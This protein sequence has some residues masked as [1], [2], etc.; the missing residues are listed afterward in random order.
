MADDAKED[1]ERDRAEREA[2]ALYLTDADNRPQVPFRKQDKS[3]RDFYFQYAREHPGL[4]R[5][6]VE[7]R[8]QLKNVLDRI[9]A[10]TVGAGCSYSYDCEIRDCHQKSMAEV[11]SIPVI[12]GGGGVCDCGITFKGDS[13]L[14]F[15]ADCPICNGTGQIPDVTEVLGKVV[16]KAMDDD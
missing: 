10:R 1:W 11:F 2:E 16:E 3:V 7:F 15:R 9:C 5:R 4:A 12:T 6:I 13:K 8:K 14:T